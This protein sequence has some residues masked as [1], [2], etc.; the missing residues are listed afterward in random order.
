[1][2]DYCKRYV[3]CP[4]YNRN[5]QHYVKCE[6]G[7]LLIFPDKETEL[8]HL[9]RFCCCDNWKACSVA[10]FLEKYFERHKEKDQVDEQKEIKKII[11]K[12]ERRG[13]CQSEPLS[14]ARKR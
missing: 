12:D 8:E 6:G 2:A 9:E 3:E 7:T 14:Q 4:F 1:M 13:S 10:I 5:G 11:K